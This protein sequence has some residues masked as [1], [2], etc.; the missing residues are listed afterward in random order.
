ML[1]VGLLRAALRAPPRGAGP[2]A[3]GAGA[4]TAGLGVWQWGVNTEIVEGAL[5]IDDLTLALTM[6][7]C[8][9][10]I[11]AVL[12]S[13]RSRAVVRGGRGRVLRAAAQLGPRHGRARRGPEPGRAVPRLRAALDPALRAVRDA[14]AARAVARVG[15]EVPDHRLGRLGDAALRPGVPLRGDGHDRLRRHR[16]RRRRPTRCSTPASRWSWR[17][18]RSRPRSRRSTSGRRT[19]TRARRPPSPRFMAVA[20][21]AAAFGVMLRL[22]DVALIGSATTWGAGAGRARA[23]H[24]R[25]RQRRRDRAVVAQA[26]AGL[27]V[28]RP[29]RLHARRRGGLDA[30]RRRRRPSST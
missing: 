6:V 9:G 21:K 19:S 11:A 14:H 24:D 7:F 26:D 2:G 25:G 10:G 20:T 18:S 8:V 30:A 5:A 13:W 22:F 16:R 27:L 23:D 17:G 1:L 3:G 29:G 4:S 28:G 15:P 12:L